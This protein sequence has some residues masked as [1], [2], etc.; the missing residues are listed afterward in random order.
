M[1]YFLQ[2]PDVMESDR[3]LKNAEF[4]IGEAEK[5]EYKGSRFTA[6]LEKLKALVKAARTLVKIIITSD[7][8]T[9]VTVY[10]VGRLGRFTRYELL[11]RPG[12]YTVVGS[13]DGYKDIRRKIIVKPDMKI[14]SITV[15]C[16][17]K[18]RP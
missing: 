6:K 15:M 1:M 7:N 12:K 13:R 17:E 5:L 16:G 18:V 11:L 14:I 9:K 8:H 3:Q 10:K 2:K 4:V